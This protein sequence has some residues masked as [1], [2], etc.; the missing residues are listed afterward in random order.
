MTKKHIPVEKPEGQGLIRFPDGKIIRVRYALAVVRV[1]DDE[2]ETGGL[3]G[4]IEVWGIIETRPDEATPNLSGKSFI[5]KTDDGR[6]LQALA[7]QRKPL[8][9][10]WEIV[11]SGPKGLEPC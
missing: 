7:K 5:L 2:A 11:S 4:H 10:E 9:R 3:T 1:L 8:T 6:C